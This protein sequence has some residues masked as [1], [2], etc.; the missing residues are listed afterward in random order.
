MSLRVEDREKKIMEMA[1]IRTEACKTRS[2]RC[3]SPHKKMLTARH[4]IGSLKNV[5]V[6]NRNAFQKVVHFVQFVFFLLKK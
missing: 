1:Q 3:F 2:Y 5:C 4:T 6:C